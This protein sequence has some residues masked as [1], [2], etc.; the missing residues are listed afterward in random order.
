MNVTGLNFINKT[1][2]IYI[3]AFAVN[4]SNFEICG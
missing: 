2:K 3:A 4:I 1:K